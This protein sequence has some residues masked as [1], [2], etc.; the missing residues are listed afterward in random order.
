[1]LHDMNAALLRLTPALLA[2][3][4]LSGCATAPAVRCA[5]HR[6]TAAGL[7]RCAVPGWEDRDVLVRLP[8]GYDATTPRPL[9]LALHGG[10]GNAENKERITCPN[11]DTSAPQCLGNLA[12]R[13][14]FIVAY[15]NGTSSRLAPRIRTWN[16]GGGHQDWRCVSG[17]A[18]E[19]GVDDVAYFRALLDELALAL[20]VDPHRVYA[21]GLSNG[22]AMSHR[23][24][25]ELPDRIAA[26]AA[27][28]GTNQLA[29]D[30]GCTPSRPVP[31]LQVHGRD[32]P[33]WAYEGGPQACLQAD[34]KR[35]A[36]VSQS[37]TAW[38][39]TNGCDP[40]P[41]TS[42][43][44]DLTPDHTTVTQTTWPNCRAPTLLLTVEGGGHTWP[45]GHPYLPERRIGRVTHDIDTETLW[46]FFEANPRP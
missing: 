26:I 17:R 33:C 11:G 8:E 23:L 10:G 21:T 37:M 19:D 36:S 46:R 16:A 43:L 35:L 22:A 27:V 7:V 41:T 44:P 39:Q 31:V 6:P 12:D 20:K 32:D 1:M 2:L 42:P 3:A 14:D 13:E 24:A 9:V 38:A 34:G 5:D 45:S 40:T 29:A 18:C 25:C 15:P 28:G 30:Q 4:A